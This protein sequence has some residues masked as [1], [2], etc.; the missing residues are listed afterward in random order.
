LVVNDRHGAV[1]QVMVAGIELMTIE[2][3]ASLP[4]PWFSM[5]KN[6]VWLAPAVIVH[7]IVLVNGL[8]VP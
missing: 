8:T 3:A 2:G 7:A 1:V 5:Q 4:E 6:C